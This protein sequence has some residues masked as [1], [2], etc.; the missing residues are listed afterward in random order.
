[1]EEM[2]V[3]DLMVPLAEYATVPEDATLFDAVMA[4]EE[5]QSKFD[6]SRERHRGILVL[7]KTGH[8]V[9][10][11]SQLDVLK[12]L[13]PQYDKIGDFRGSSRLGFSPEFIRSLLKNYGLWDKPLRDICRKAAQIKVKDIFYTPGKAEYVREEDSLNHAIHQLI[14]GHHQSLLVTRGNEIVGIL[15]L[16]D[17]FREICGIIKTCQV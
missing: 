11:L 12:G 15:R 13:E 17:V 16:S 8:V 6:R 10:K 5:A 7:D 1:M 2:K 4:L 14:V 3:K 9:G